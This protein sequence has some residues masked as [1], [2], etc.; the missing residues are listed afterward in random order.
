MRDTIWEHPNIY[1]HDS[2]CVKYKDIYDA[3]FVLKDEGKIYKF[4]SYNGIIHV[5]NSNNYNERE[6]KIFHINDLQKYIYQ[7]QTIS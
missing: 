4:W 5:K 3:C 7:N 6:K 2:L 1:I